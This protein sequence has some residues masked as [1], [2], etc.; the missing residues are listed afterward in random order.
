ME[1]GRSLR[2]RSIPRVCFRLVARGERLMYY[3]KLAALQVHFFFV[4]LLTVLVPRDAVQEASRI[5]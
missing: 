2:R 3:G 4:R 1:M 5:T